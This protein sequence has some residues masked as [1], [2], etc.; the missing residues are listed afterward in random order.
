M[1][2]MYDDLFIIYLLFIIVFSYYESMHCLDLQNFNPNLVLLLTSKEEGAG[3]PA[4]VIASFSFFS[5]L[6]SL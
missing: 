3:M 6:S 4:L 2:I 1:I 5:F